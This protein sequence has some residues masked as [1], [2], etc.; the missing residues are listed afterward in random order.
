MILRSLLL[1]N[2]PLFLVPGAAP[3][4]DKGSAHLGGA[5]KVVL[6]RTNSFRAAEGLG[7]L[8]VND[9]LTAAAQYFADFM[10]RTDKYG[11]SADG[12]EPWDRAK[13]HGYEYCLIAE[14]IA[15]V[16]EPRGFT[17]TGL[18]DKLF[19]G[20]KN[21]PPH[22]KNMLDPGMLDIGIGIA[23]SPR[24]GRYYGVQLFG[25]H[26]SKMISFRIENRGDQPVEYLVDG[27]RFTLLPSYT[28][29]HPAL[30]PLD[31]QVSLPGGGE[32]RTLR[33]SG[34]EHFVVQR[35]PGAAWKLTVGR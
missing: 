19:A 12:T 27:N 9:E 30:R 31:L 17:A 29:T 8:A 11:H 6:E 26:A 24:T 21:S 13:N 2:V 18:G 25:R 33:P 5:I 20:W 14:N 32:V 3:A 15:W 4:Q 35:G 23:Y 7:R 10:A 22:R 1:L 16:M 34:G 28:R